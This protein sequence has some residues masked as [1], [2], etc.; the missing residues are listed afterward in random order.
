MNVVMLG[1]GRFVEVQGTAEGEAF[2]KR[3]FASVL[4]LA[5]AGIRQLFELQRTALGQS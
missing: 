5:D 3:D 1:T 4:D 2:S